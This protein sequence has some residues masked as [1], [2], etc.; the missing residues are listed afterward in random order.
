MIDWLK[1]LLED[2]NGIPDEAR[3]SAMLLVLG[4][5]GA[6]A[7][8]IVALKHAFNAQAY[9]IGAAALAAGVGAW[10]GFRGKN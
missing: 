1:K 4:F 10:M 5:L 2:D 3:V 8:D 9:G 7:W 6:A